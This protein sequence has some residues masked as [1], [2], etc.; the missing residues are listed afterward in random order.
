MLAQVPEASGKAMRPGR[1]GDPA[2]HAVDRYSEAARLMTGKPA[3][4]IEDGLAWIRETVALL[5]IPGLAA[6]GLR[7]QHAD[8]VAAKAARSSSMKG[9][10]TALSQGD[11]RAIFLRAL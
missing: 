5:A 6:F 10:P 3:A 7:P 8:D 9:N 2:R 1:R 11:L 4:S